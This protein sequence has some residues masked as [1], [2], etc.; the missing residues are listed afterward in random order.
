M[1]TLERAMSGVIPSQ[2][3]FWKKG[4]GGGAGLV[5]VPDVTFGLCLPGA[6]QS[7]IGFWLHVAQVNTL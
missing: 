4:G 5:E 1:D 3:R 7:N 6:P 2:G